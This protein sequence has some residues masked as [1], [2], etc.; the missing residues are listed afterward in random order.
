MLS[1]GKKYNDIVIFL[2]HRFLKILFGISSF[3]LGCNVSTPQD[4][5]SSI[6]RTPVSVPSLT[7]SSLFKSRVYPFTIV[8]L[9][10]KARNGLIRLPGMG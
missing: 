4:R 3:S 9:H 5:T 6:G 8:L 1:F 7:G 2:K 10:N